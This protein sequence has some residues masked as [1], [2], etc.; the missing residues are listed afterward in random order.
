MGQTSIFEEREKWNGAIVLAAVLHLLLAIVIV[1]AGMI[2]VRSGENWGGSTSGEAVQANL[3][4]AVPLPAPQQPTQN[5][6][7]TEN[8][9]LTQSIPQQAEEQPDAVPIP[10]KTKKRRPE[11]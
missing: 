10:D 4:S 3:V 7:A 5:I 6:V 11:K 9:G 2:G 8:K 1:V